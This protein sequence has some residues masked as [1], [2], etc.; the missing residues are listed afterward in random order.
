[1]DDGKGMWVCLEEFILDYARLTMHVVQLDIQVWHALNTSPDIQCPDCMSFRFLDALAW[2]LQI[3]N[4]PYWRVLDNLYDEEPRDL[5]RRVR[6]RFITPDNTRK[7]LEFTTLILDNA[8]RCPSLTAVLSSILTLAA[9]LLDNKQKQRLRGDIDAES[10]ID[11]IALQ[12]I[13]QII[14]QVHEKWQ[15]WITN[16]SAWAGSDLS[17]SLVR[18]LG[19]ANNLLCYQDEDFLHQLEKGLLLGV[20][21][22]LNARDHIFLVVWG[23][24]FGVL[25][26]HVM[27]GRM[28]LRAFGVETMQSDL[29]TVWRQ[30]ISPEPASAGA[31]PLVQYL[32]RLIQSTKL[33]DYLVGVDSHPQLIS[34]SSNIIGF[35][36]VT[37]TYTNSE[38]DIIWKTITDSQ[39][40]RIIAEVLTM[41]IKTLYMH[42]LTSPCLLYICSKVLDLPLDRFDGRMLDLC[43]GLLLRASSDKPIDHAGKESLDAVLIRLCVRLIREST[44]AGDIPVDQKTHMQTFGSKHLERFIKAG[45]SE[46]DRMEIYERC[47]QDIGEMNQFTAGSFQVLNVLVPLQDSQETWKLATD[48]D[49]TRLVIKDL[50][51][52]V[53]DDE[54]DFSNSFSHH[55]LISRIA[56]LSRLVDMAPDTITPELGSSLWNEIFLSKKL[57]Q[58]GLKAVWSMM[59]NALK[60]SSKPNPF[61]DRCIYEYLPGLKPSDYSVDLLAFAKHSIMYE[62]RFYPPSLPSENEVITIPG[63]DRIWTIILNAPPSSIENDAMKFAVEVYLDHTIML[64]SPRS[65][66]ELT[67]ISIANRCIDQLKSAATALTESEKITAKGTEFEMEEGSEQKLSADEIR[68]RR[69]LI[70]LRQFLYGLRTRPHYSPPR[71]TPPRLPDRPLK[72]DAIEITWQAFN[73]SSSSKINHLR[74]G[75]LS[76]S[77]EL[78][79]RF[80][81][82]TG[83]SKLTTISGGQR[84]DLLKDPDVFIK[85]L[86]LQPGLLIVQR[87]ADA[88]EVAQ[89]NRRQV[90]TPVDFQ[91]LQHFN[92]MYELLALRA[93]LA[94]EIFEFLVV[95]PPQERITSIVRSEE[96]DQKDLFPLQKPFVALY[97]FNALTAC[98]REEA[99]QDTP[100]STFVSHSIKILV[101]FLLS[102]EL[103]GLLSQNRLVLNLAASAVECL[104]LTFTIHKEN[105]EDNPIIQ[106]PTIFVKQLLRL[107]EAVRAIPENHT[108]IHR[109]QKF[110]C[111]SFALLIEGSVKDHAYWIAVKGE[112]QFDQLVEAMLLQEESRQARIEVSD[113]VHMIC[114]SSKLQKYSTRKSSD[115]TDQLAESPTRIDM[116]ATIWESLSS[117]IPKTLNYAFQS[118]EFFK[119]TLWV[120]NSIA[121][122]SPKDMSFSHYLRQWSE[123]MFQHQ[124]EE[125]IGREIVDEVVHGFALLLELCIELADACK[126]QLDTFDLGEKLL[127]K[128]LFPEL[129]PDDE[130]PVVAQTPVMH[131]MTR[132]KL[133]SIIT[134]ICKRNSAN[135]VRTFEFMSDLIP[136]DESYGPNSSIESSNMIRAT[137]GY[138]G[139]KNLSNTCYLNSLITQLFMNVEFREF[140]LG[141]HIV[142][143]ESSQKLLSETQRLFAGMQGS[144]SKHV[145]PQEFVESIRTYD[146]E[147]I[148]VTVQMDVDEFYN[149]LF[150]R[151]EA[152][153]VDSEDKK[154][155]RSFYGGQLVQQIK[156]KECSHISERLEPFSAIQCDIKG[157]VS[158]EESLQAYVEGE[159]MQGGMLN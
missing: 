124:I 136:R 145:N 142:D 32:V 42:P 67:H 130:D 157:K 82:A 147:A 80:S 83:F 106:E 46:V 100:N 137:E 40:S 129:S 21:D 14:S 155:F 10:P 3:Q 127:A 36:I 13:R 89:D 64:N 122:K 139:L 39:D 90:F 9:T 60:N 8:A 33:V 45:I 61:L 52:T 35:L 81:Q 121:D 4:L 48:F 58:S 54:N 158:L 116:L 117:T 41:L 99:I 91:V 97:S 5:I 65:A 102:P 94:R 150:D 37:S 148:D 56:M 12:I 1:M 118:A 110:K 43:E 44:V 73:G 87:A 2:L 79:E 120:F 126:I 31:S 22:D 138:A 74:I 143:P 103:S 51:H 27:E 131:S 59:V 11:P 18:Q 114:G 132:Q 92:E 25:K 93:D 152:Q 23:W 47:I 107:V 6:A 86:K 95:F 70:F 7:L 109:I 53:N 144:W 28:E 134:L 55:G 85:D 69:S 34:R 15:S 96:H 26:R 76:T 72:G 156:S 128:Y 78:V 141:L 68:F 104:L 146:N 112:V 16:K 133:F 149:L 111:N 115:A 123:V 101:G 105:D 19:R 88:R 154:R 75:E 49:L 113:R 135:L 84:I 20:P 57:G 77:A 63:M 140:M 30:Y 98:L 29:V 151:W 119:T 108:N 125:F 38:T 17:E 24:K 71:G 50:L 62:L 66:V 159:I 153:V